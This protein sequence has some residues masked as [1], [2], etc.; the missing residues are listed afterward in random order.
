MPGDP[1]SGRPRL[2]LSRG[3][4]LSTPLPFRHQKV[5]RLRRLA[6]RRSAREAERVFVA[7]GVKVVAEAL[8]AGAPI[9]SV[10]VDARAMAG[11]PPS[12]EL[13]ALLDDAATA[14]IR[15]FPLAGGV[16]DRVT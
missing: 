14:G 7:E 5:Q 12:G 2:P 9:E 15:V 16:L 6:S 1:A 11:E 8:A 13:A 4:H 3:A 10:F